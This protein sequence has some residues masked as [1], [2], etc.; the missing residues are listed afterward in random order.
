MIAGV[1]FMGELV[2]IFDFI[3]AVGVIACAFLIYRSVK[4][5]EGVEPNEKAYTRGFNDAVKY[6]GIKKLYSED[7]E[8][9]KHMQEVFADAGI[10][11]R[12]YGIAQQVK[13]NSVKT[14]PTKNPRSL[15]D[16]S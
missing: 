7:P 5:K 1:F 13:K 10:E 11:H 9:Y 3:A 4:G 16:P 2:L 14:A 6:F 12:I 15:G 8:L